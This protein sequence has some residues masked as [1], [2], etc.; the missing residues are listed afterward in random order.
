MT[1]LAKR[2]NQELPGGVLSAAH[3][4]QYEEGLREMGCVLPDD[5][6]ELEEADLMEL[7][8]KKIEIKRL[9]RSAT[10]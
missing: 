2:I 4:S 5:L 8:M 9:L 1:S 7:G 10:P 6:R 3:L